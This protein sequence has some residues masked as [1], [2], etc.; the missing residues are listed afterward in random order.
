MMF[1]AQYIEHLM[2]TQDIED[3]K[4]IGLFGLKKNSEILGP[5]SKH[6]S[7]S[8]QPKDSDEPQPKSRNLEGLH[9]R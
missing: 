8:S 2:I 6:L 3:R 9:H 4:Q 7:G 1:E 5:H